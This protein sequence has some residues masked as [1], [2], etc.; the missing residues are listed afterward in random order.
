MD[1]I[2]QAI[3]GHPA[4]DLLRPQRPSLAAWYAGPLA[5]G[6]LARLQLAAA[7]GLQSRLCKGGSSFRPQLLQLVCCSLAGTDIEPG[8]RQLRATLHAARDTALLE[9]VY[10]QLLISRKLRPAITYL[11][12]GFMRAARYLDSSDYLRLLRRH[13]LLDCLVLTGKPADPQP[14]DALLSEAAVIRRLREH[15]VRRNGNAHHDTVG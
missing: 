2:K 10:G 4:A 8:Y 11:E 15:T 1:G 5:A 6:K 7:T 3:P 12:R 13:E 9:L 14:L